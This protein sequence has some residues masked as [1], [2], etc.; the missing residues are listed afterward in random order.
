MASKYGN[1][2][3]LLNAGSTVIG[4]MTGRQRHGV[5]KGGERE[6]GGER[7]RETGETGNGNGTATGEAGDSGGGKGTMGRGK[8]K[9]RPLMGTAQAQ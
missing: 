8:G 2:R 9:K 3:S 7:I 5:G 6:R 1:R 4:R